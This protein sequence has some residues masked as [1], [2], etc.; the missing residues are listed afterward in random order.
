MI[1]KGIFTHNECHQIHIMNVDPGLSKIYFILSFSD[2]YNSSPVPTK[3][4]SKGFLERNFISQKIKFI[5]EK[6]FDFESP[7]IRTTFFDKK[8]I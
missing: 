8:F 4:P 6:N 1:Q 5:N 2:Y 3:D 7:K